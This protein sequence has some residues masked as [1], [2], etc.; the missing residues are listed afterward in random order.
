MKV[1]CPEGVSDVSIGG[2]NFT[3]DKN[4]VIELPDNG[5]HFSLLPA[6]FAV[7]TAETKKAAATKEAPQS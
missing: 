3:P 6:G 2:E 7:V 5:N 1:Q 4:G